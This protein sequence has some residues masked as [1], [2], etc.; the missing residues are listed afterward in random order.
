MQSRHR[1]SDHTRWPRCLELAMSYPYK[2]VTDRE[3]ALERENERLTDQVKR[4]SATIHVQ[5]VAIQSMT[6]EIEG[7]KPDAER[8]RALKRRHGYLMVC[9][10]IGET[11]YSSQKSDGIIDAFADN[12]IKEIA[13][14][15][16]KTQE[17]KNEYFIT[18]SSAVIKAS[19]AMK[20]TKS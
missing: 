17:E 18:K 9:R 1:E 8:Y 15:N 5:A 2:I 14:W 11:G 6:E 19:A 7:L 10:L 4:Q 3:I 12:A 13:E 20:E 16:S